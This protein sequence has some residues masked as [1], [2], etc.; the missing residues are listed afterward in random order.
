MKVLTDEYKK[1]KK[2]ALECY[3]LDM[4]IHE[5]EHFECSSELIESVK[6][7]LKIKELEYENL[8]R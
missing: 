4:E 3:M 1:A 8:N 5:L 7:L 2:I 6:K